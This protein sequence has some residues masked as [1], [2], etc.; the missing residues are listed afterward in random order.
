MNRNTIMIG[1]VAYDVERVYDGSSS[2]PEL[3]CDKLANLL[4]ENEGVDGSHAISY[5]KK[6][7]GRFVEGGD[8]EN[9]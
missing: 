4:Y 1:N 7:I 3:L 2:V 9:R 5:N 8:Y 6:D